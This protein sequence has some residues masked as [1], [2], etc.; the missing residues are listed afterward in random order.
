V[1]VLVCVTF[2][3]CSVVNSEPPAQTPIVRS[4][5][6]TRDFSPAS[7]YGLSKQQMIDRLGL[8]LFVYERTSNSLVTRFWDGRAFTNNYEEKMD[9]GG[10]FKEVTYSYSQPAHTAFIFLNNEDRIVRGSYSNRAF[11]VNGE[12]GQAVYVCP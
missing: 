5:P 9:L 6:P 3:L 8:P 4:E 10:N 12:H 7:F 11:T 1:V 2:G